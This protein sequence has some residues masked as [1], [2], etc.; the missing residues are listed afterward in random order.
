[1]TTIVKPVTTFAFTSVQ[2][3]VT[4]NFNIPAQTH[5]EACKKLISAL[6]VIAAEVNDIMKPA[7]AN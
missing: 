5:N 4:Y 2:G 3:E 1:M 7:G 6:T